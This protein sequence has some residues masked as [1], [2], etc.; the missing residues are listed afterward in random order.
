MS[1]SLDILHSFEIG[2][3]I[4]I[5]LFFIMLWNGVIEQWLDKWDQ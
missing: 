1:M 3:C 2:F 5:A 4:G